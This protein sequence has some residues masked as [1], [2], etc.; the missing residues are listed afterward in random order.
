MNP[1]EITFTEALAATALGVDNSIL[2]AG[3]NIARGRATSQKSEADATNTESLLNKWMTALVPKVAQ[4]NNAIDTKI[5]IDA[6]ISIPIGLSIITGRAGSGKTS[7]LRESVI[8]NLPENINASYLKI[9]EPGYLIP[10]T[11]DIL[12]NVIETRIMEANK[13]PEI[14]GILLIDSLLGVWFDPNITAG[15]A[16]G[17]GGASLGVPV[18]LQVIGQLA[19]VNGFRIVA[20]LH[21]VFADPE[22]IGSGISGVSSMFLNKDDN[23]FIIRDYTKVPNDADASTLSSIPYIRREVNMESSISDSLNLLTSTVGDED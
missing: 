6:D 9:G 4:I 22:V 20:V 2:R 17:R 16:T 11:L 10:Y 12:L 3:F 21:P 1:K 8:P 18:L 19:L 13:T 5:L 23:A 15:F 14:A 7:W